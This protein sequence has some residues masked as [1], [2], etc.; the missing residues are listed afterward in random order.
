MIEEEEEFEDY[1]VTEQEIEDFFAI[2]EIPKVAK[3]HDYSGILAEVDRKY[4]DGKEEEFFKDIEQSGLRG[5]EYS[6]RRIPEIG[7]SFRKYIRDLEIQYTAYKIV[8][9]GIPSE[10]RAEEEPKYKALM[11]SLKKAIEA[12]KKELL[13]VE[14]KE[15]QNFDD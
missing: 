4:A 10:Y 11:K 9:E 3:E 15:R 1:N 5:H 14:E 6:Q 2:E 7:K 13:K 12:N 8:F